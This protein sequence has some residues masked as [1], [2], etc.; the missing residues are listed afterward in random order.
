MADFSILS[1]FEVARSLAAIEAVGRASKPV[2][3]VGNVKLSSSR[4]AELDGDLAQC[5][6]L[7]GEPEVKPFVLRE[8]GGRWSY[9]F[10]RH[11]WARDALEFLRR[12]HRGA[13]LSA[14]DRD[15]IAGLLFG[16]SPE[17]IQRFLTGAAGSV[18][19]RST[20]PPDC[21]EGMEGT[22]R[23]RL[24]RSRTRSPNSDRFLT[25]G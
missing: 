17:A 7:A 5:L 6:R 24:G 3:E 9:G 20:L 22:V 2:A 10:Y 15:W 1:D 4:V 13:R 16:Y 25:A 19:P 8:E 12:R 21:G 11:S 18:G 23:P 14:Y